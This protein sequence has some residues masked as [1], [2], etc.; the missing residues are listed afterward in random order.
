MIHYCDLDE[1]FPVSTSAVAVPRSV[2]PD[3]FYAPDHMRTSEYFQD[4]DDDVD[5]TTY[6]T[7]ISDIT[8]IEFVIIAM[9]CLILFDSFSRHL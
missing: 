1:A 9:I 8:F 5:A 3:E 6:P 7:K 4:D 2:L